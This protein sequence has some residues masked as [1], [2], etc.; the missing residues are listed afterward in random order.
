MFTSILQQIPQ[1]CVPTHF[2]ELPESLLSFF[3]EDSIIPPLDLHNPSP[4]HTA[5]YNAFNSF[6]KPCF[7]K[8]SGNAPTDAKWMSG[9]LKVYSLNNGLCLLKA[10]DRCSF[11]SY[12][13][14]LEIKPFVEIDPAHEFRLVVKQGELKAIIQRHGEYF[15]PGIISG[16]HYLTQKFTRF[17][18]KIQ[19]TISDNSITYLINIYFNCKNC[20]WEKGTV[21]ILDISEFLPE[22]FPY[23][24]QLT[25]Q[26][27]Q[28]FAVE[29]PS[30]VFSSPIVSYSGLPIEVYNHDDGE[31]VWELIR[32]AK[33]EDQSNLID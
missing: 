30:L 20:E 27:C 25:S 12:P 19:H 6:H 1:Y 18:S 8:L 31:A 9:D 3:S 22:N 14:F 33:R 32:S 4:D 23:I 2:I 5:L 21:R 29:D 10:S 15:F 13:Q 17:I 11:D 7:F 24:N 28:F 26:D 16:K